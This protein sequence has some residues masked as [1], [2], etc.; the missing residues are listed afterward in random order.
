[1]ECED[2][3]VISDEEAER[4]ADVKELEDDEDTIPRE[5]LEALGKYEEM[6]TLLSLWGVG[7]GG[8]GGR[9]QET[10][11]DHFETPTKLAR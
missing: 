2:G 10:I 6:N 8:G 5:T 3:E 11:T 7:G 1:M 4:L 9:G